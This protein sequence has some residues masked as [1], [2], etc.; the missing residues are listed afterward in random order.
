MIGL[1]ILVL[2]AVVFNYLHTWYRR[3]RAVQKA[4]QILSS[5]TLRSFDRIEYSEYSDKQKKFPRFRLIA[6]RGHEDREGMSY[7]EGIEAYDFNPD[8][9]IRN[10]IRSQKAEYDRN[11]KLAHFSGDV[12]LSLGKDVELRMHSLDYDFNSKTGTTEDRLELIADAAR[13]SARGVRFDQS[14]GSMDLKSEVSFV[15][16]AGEPE[17]G[18]VAK[19][20]RFHAT[21]DR[22]FCADQ[23]HKIVFQGGARIESESA[24]LSG[25]TIEALLGPERKEITSLVSIGNA[26][27]Q[28]GD[29]S[30]KQSLRGDRMV[31]VISELQ[32]LE[33]ISIAGQAEFISASESGEEVLH[34]NEIDLEFDPA[35]KMPRQIEGR[36]DVSFSRKHSGEQMQVSGNRL[37]A[38][39]VPGTNNLENLRVENNAALAVQSDADGMLNELQAA[40]I[41]LSFRQSNERMVL[42][43]LRA[44]GS[45]RW[46][47][48]PLPERA[49]GRKEP[50]RILAASTLEMLYSRE[51]DSFESGTAGGGVVISENGDAVDSRAPSRRLLADQVRFHFFTGNNRL[52]DMEGEGHVQII[53][54]KK[55]SAHGKSS[56]DGFRTSSE[57]MKVLFSLRQ[58]ESAVESLSQWGSFTYE[59]ASMSATAGRCDYDAQKELL[60]LRENPRISNDMNSTTGMWM[61]YEQKAGVLSVHQRVRSLLNPATN[62]KSFFASSSSSSPAIVTAEGM[63]YWR[64]GQRARYEGKVQL[65]SENG[66]LQAGR[67]DIVE[68][69]EIVDAGTGVRHSFIHERGE[70][71]P[72]RNTDKSK[73]ARQSESRRVTILCSN[74]RYLRKSNTITYTGAVT[75][76]SEDIDIS[77]NSLEVRI[78]DESGSVEHAVARHKVNI[79][80]G[81]RT[82]K[83]DRVDYF[84]NQR[85]FVLVGNPAELNDPERGRSIGSQLTYFIADDRILLENQ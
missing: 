5:E 83:G 19:S 66:Q 42:E 49:S 77:S 29:S 68:G 55:S 63:K 35:T 78:A 60:T 41:R 32:A 8:G 71:K 37:T 44:E 2:F 53:Q 34:G 27:Y 18:G 45:A 80:N 65:L 76:H 48:R 23:L 84:L 62:E 30:R 14:Q 21:S 20:E 3:A 17:A 10:E 1:I 31:F 70:S 38:S 28:S 51:G 16:T 79:R 12:R 40:E 85:M 39:F 57:K 15:L 47:S 82:G 43:K 46:L 24:V 64:D 56:V 6:R 59:D 13:G 67:L 73:E 61:E 36:N 75:A 74:L 52:R 25:E 58:N 33:R 26:Q 9:S 11:H 4:A 7:L 22:A 50:A 81:D 69:G 72:L 54:E